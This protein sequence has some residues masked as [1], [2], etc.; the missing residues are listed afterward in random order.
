VTRRASFASLAAL[1]LDGLRRKVGRNLLTMSGVFIGVFALTLIVSLGEGMTRLVQSAVSGEDNLRQIGLSGGLGTPLDEDADVEI[2]GAMSDARRERLRRAALARTRP[3]T[4]IGRRVRSIDPA[5]LVELESLP[6]VEA[7]RPIVLERYRMRAGEHASEVTTT[8]GVDVGRRRYEDRVIAGR[9][10]S[11]PDADEALVHE[12]LAY[13][14]GCVSDEDLAGLVGTRMVLEPIRNRPGGGFGAP[15][16]VADALARLDLSVLSPEEREMFPRIVE[17][18]GRA[19]L[20]S[21]DELERGPDRHEVTIVGVVRELE[22]GDPLRVIEDGNASRVDVFL[23]LE[24]ATRYFFAEPVNREI[25]F[26]R[27][28]VVV[29]E[30]HHVSEVEAELRRRGFTAFSVAS[31]VARIDD[32]LGALTIVVALL[33]GV[34]LLVAALGIVNTMV[35]S[36]LE[37]T[38]EI[39]LWKAVGAT[40]AQVRTV[41]LLEAG[42]IGL[43]G[44]LLGLGIALLV[45]IP[46]DGVALRMIAERAAFPVRG[47]VFHVPAWLP[48]AGPALATVVAMLAALYPAYRAARV[49]PVRALRHE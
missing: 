14:W 25:G 27:S 41:F 3:G 20:G 48:V 19:M 18:L 21:L 49:D 33:T 31:V 42:L 23:P 10:F 16:F 17:K 44:G 22:P 32:F 28:Y 47:S 29:D 46:A 13:Q 37:R 6:H 36:V 43:V 26:G 2:Q 12:Y 9:Y 1:A 7:A 8:L 15:G 30:S 34:A 35:T 5:T 24:T 11:S 4:F 40:S 45:Q 38:H 39:G